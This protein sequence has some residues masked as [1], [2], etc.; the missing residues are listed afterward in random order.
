MRV[1][2]A[3]QDEELAAGRNGVTVN[4]AKLEGGG[5]YNVVPDLAIARFN[6]RV[7]TVADMHDVE[8]ELREA[9]R[10]T[11]EAEGIRAELHGEFRARPRPVCSRMRV[12]M[13]EIA[14]CAAE[15]GIAVEWRPTGGVC[16][17]NR[18]AAAGLPTVDTLGP[19]GGGLHSSDEHL[20][21]D[22]LT[23]RAR[24]SALLLMKLA[25]GDIDAARFARSR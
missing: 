14:T 24:L 6:V 10:R 17:G 9:V 18:L 11:G 20:D 1:F 2:T 16:D 21:V 7:E 15:L 23:E 4:V 12:L 5:P 3:A 8:R 22:S 19:C 25:A 13:D